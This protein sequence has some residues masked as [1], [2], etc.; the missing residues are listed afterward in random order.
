M[1]PISENGRVLG[2]NDAMSA[3]LGTPAPSTKAP[4]LEEW[5]TDYVRAIP[6]LQS[7][8]GRAKSPMRVAIMRASQMDAGRL[9]VELTS[10]L[11]EQF[12][13]AFTWVQPRLLNALRPELTLLLD[14]LIFHFSVWKGKPTPGSALMNLRYRDESGQ[15]Q[16]GGRTGVEGPGLSLRQ[17]IGWGAAF[18]FGRYAWGRLESV[19]TACHW[20]DQGQASLAYRSWRTMQWM[21]GAY[22]IASLLN[23]VTFLR[24]GRYRN[25][26]ERVLQSRLVYKRASMPRALN[27]EY[28]NRQLVWHELSELLLFLLPLVNVTRI[29]SFVMKNLPQMYQPRPQSGGVLVERISEEHRCNICRKENVAIPFE[30][31]PCQ[32]KF[33]YYC[34]RSHTESEAGYKC[35]ACGEVVQSMRRWQPS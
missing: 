15:A 12:M 21:E 32:H 22:K 23:F 5:Q 11:Q 24:F 2:N 25:L 6:E 18:V 29:R 27:F 4:A 26:A 33:C 17:R 30:A 31:L 8:A 28:L 9:D 20:G 14:Y 7:L 3:N 19:A 10:M 35:P 1:V 16:V 34:L 13:K